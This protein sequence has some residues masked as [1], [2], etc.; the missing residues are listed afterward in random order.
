MPGKTKNPLAEGMREFMRGSHSGG[1]PDCE[2]ETC[3]QKRSPRRGEGT[4][5]IAGQFDDAVVQQFRVLA[6]HLTRN[7]VHLD[8]C[9]KP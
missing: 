6:A 8:Y 4:R 3:P 1:A 5:I 9:R 2:H 7:A